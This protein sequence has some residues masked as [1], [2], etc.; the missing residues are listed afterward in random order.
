MND[1]NIFEMIADKYVNDIDPTGNKQL[2]VKEHC[3][4]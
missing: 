1:F 4:T 3:S 2:K